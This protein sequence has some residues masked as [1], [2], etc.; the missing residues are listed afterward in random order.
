MSWR[1]AFPLQACRGFA[2]ATIPGTGRELYRQ[3]NV[4]EMLRYRDK[5][6][7]EAELSKGVP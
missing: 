3:G 2:D 7:E 6:R 1:K 4:R 5:S